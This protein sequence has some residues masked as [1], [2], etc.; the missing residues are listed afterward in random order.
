[1]A[2]DGRPISQLRPGASFPR[3]PTVAS[4]PPDSRDGDLKLVQ[5]CLEGDSIAL[6]KLKAEYLDPLRGVLINRGAYLTEADDMVRGLWADCVMGRNDRG[7]LLERYNGRSSLR[8]WLTT[9]ATH[10][11]VDQLR[12]RKFRKE[13]V[14]RSE[15]EGV[16]E[17]LQV[18]TAFLDNPAESDLTRLL[19]TGLKAGF[20]AC[21]AEELLM[22]RL[23]FFHGFSQRD[24]CRLWRWTE[25]RVSRHLQSAYETIRDNT[26][27]C[28]KQTD[29]ALKLSL[30]DFVELCRTH[31]LEFL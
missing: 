17:I 22:I 13:P 19:L 18:L 14:P 2:F 28:I 15:E 16:E 12:R 21:P 1:M 31:E 6:E 4:E 11:L 30:E 9:V 25:P 7:P 10:A 27:A 24:L 26:L 23:V 3:L 5:A 29:P 20:D 8:S